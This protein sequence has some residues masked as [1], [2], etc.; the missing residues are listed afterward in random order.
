[1]SID[2]QH[3]CKN[4]NGFIKQ[5]ETQNPSIARKKITVLDDYYRSTILESAI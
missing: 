3:P 1:M 5:Y 2:F 4:I